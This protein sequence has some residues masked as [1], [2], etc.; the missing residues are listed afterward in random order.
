TN[1]K[2]HRSIPMIFYK[3]MREHCAI[4]HQ[5]TPTSRAARTHARTITSP[6]RAATQTLLIIVARSTRR[7]PQRAQRSALRRS[8]S[9][10]RAERASTTRSN[11]HNHAPASQRI[12][13]VV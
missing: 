1:Q 2:T 10:P 3:M 5:H 12:D 9:A 6:V 4:T 13:F 7:A 8:H 11:E